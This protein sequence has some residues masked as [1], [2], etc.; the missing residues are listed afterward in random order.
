MLNYDLTRLACNRVNL[1]LHRLARQDVTK[2]HNTV[3][4]CKN[5]CC[6]WIPRYEKVTGLDLLAVFDHK[7][8]TIDNRISLSLSAPIVHNGELAALAIHDHKVS[9]C[10]FDRIDSYIFDLARICSSAIGLFCRTTSCAADME[11]PHGQLC[12]GLSNR[13]R[14]QDS[15]WRA[16]FHGLAI[17]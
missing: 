4:L 1:F 7:V 8:G 3:C 17:G 16:D 9:V 10:I 5:R 6:V 12:A 14:C 2:L 13:L 11:C 15:D